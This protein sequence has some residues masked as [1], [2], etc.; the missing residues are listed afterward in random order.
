M[1]W[2][3]IVLL[4]IDIIGNIYTIKRVKKLEER[5]YVLEWTK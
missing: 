5:I 4:V 1:E 3:L 2:V